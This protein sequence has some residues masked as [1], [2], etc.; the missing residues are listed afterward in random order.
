VCSWTRSATS[1]VPQTD[2][3]PCF[4]KRRSCGWRH[5]Q[6]SGSA[7][8]RHQ[9]TPRRLVKEGSFRPDLYYGLHVFCIDLPPRGTGR[10]YSAAVN[11]FLKQSAW[12][13]ARHAAALGEALEVLIRHDWPG[14]VRELGERRGTGAGGGR[15]RKS[16]GDFSFQFQAEEPKGTETLDDVERSHIER[17]LRETRTIS[18]GGAHPG[19]RPHHLYNKLRVTDCGETIIHPAGAPSRPGAEPGLDLWSISPR[20]WRARSHAVP[21]SPETSIFFAL[22]AGRQQYY[23]TAII[24][25][26]ER[27]V[28]PDVRV[29]R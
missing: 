19:Y 28:N 15:V 21:D 13:P 22:D 9:R 12:P 29:R 11:H 7:A 10:R 17:I 4:R 18:P 2:L 26:L 16:P 23:S 27:A 25:R 6:I 3:L 5:Q 24:Q 1:A 8:S 20:R 14:N